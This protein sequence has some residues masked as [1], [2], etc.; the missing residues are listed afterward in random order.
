ML[1]P[2]CFSRWTKSNRKHRQKNRSVE[3]PAAPE[4]IRVKA[5]IRLSQSVFA[6]LETARSLTGNLEFSGLG[7]VTVQTIH[8]ETLYDIYDVVIL[9]VGS[10]GFTEIQGEDI[11]PLLDRPDAGNMKLWFHRHP[12]GNNIPGPHNWSAM[13]NQTIEE[14]PLGGVPELVKWSLSIVRTP[15][16]WVG[17]VDHY[18]P[19]GVQ[20]SHIPVIVVVDPCWTRRV[21]N[22]RKQYEEQF[23]RSFLTKEISR[24]SR[25]AGIFRF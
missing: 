3:K 16:A 9:N 25:Q 2:I 15:E 23:L 11:L 18:L 7:F 1:N 21:L 13:D 19:E 22:L 20:T 10:P 4:G 6:R 5:T 17:R 14:E 24:A 12:K 8:H